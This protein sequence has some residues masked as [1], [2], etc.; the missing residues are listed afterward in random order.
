MGIV[1]I[2]LV[3][4][5]PA[6]ADLVIR[7]LARLL[8]SPQ[9]IHISDGESALNYILRQKDYTSPESSPRPNLILLD[10][11]LPRVNGLDVL[12]TIK[13]TS[14]VNDIPIVVLTSSAMDE[15]VKEA[16]QAGA[17]SY[18]VKPFDLN[19]LPKLIFKLID[20]PSE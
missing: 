6:H 14:D 3:E 19:G 7:S 1:R 16:E 20:V 4:D 9:V 13:N 11:R 18:V 17:A 5:N 2:L 12:R 8:P 15:E 10:L